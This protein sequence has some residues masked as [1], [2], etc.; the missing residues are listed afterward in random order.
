[1][2]LGIII[3]QFINLINQNKNQMKKL[4]VLMC[5]IA[6]LSLVFTSCKKDPDQPI[7]DI[8]EDGFYVLGAA[9]GY[10]DLTVK[11]VSACQMANGKNEVSKAAREGMYEKYI[12]LEGGKDFMILEK[13]GDKNNQYT[14]ALE[15]KNI[16]TDGVDLEGG[17]WGKV[18][19]GTAMMQVKETGLYH[20]VLDMNL[21]KQ[22]DAA[23]GAQIIIAPVVWG[24]RGAMNGWSYTKFDGEAKENGAIT[25]AWKNQEMGADNAEFKFAHGN[26]WKINL[27]VAEQVKA[28][29]SL[30]KDMAAGGEN[31]VVAE[32]GMY[33]ITLTFQMSKGEIAKSFSMEAKK[34]GDIAVKDYSAV[35]LE[36]VGDAVADQ[37]GATPDASSWGWGNVYPLGKPVKSGDIYTWKSAG[38]VKLLGGKKYKVRTKGFADQGD[39]KAFDNGADIE[40]AA[41]TEVEI[42]VVLDAQSGKMTV[43]DGSVPADPVMVTVKA[44]MPADWTET[45]TAWVWPTGGDGV[46]AELTK[47]G[48]WYVYTTPE[49][50]TALNIIWRNGNDWGKGQ[51]VNVEGLR[52]NACYTI[53]DATDVDAEGKRNVTSVDCQ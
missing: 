44:K 33:D 26:F 46:A 38:K 11:G 39:I 3:T 49:P 52:A 9:A 34:V 18:S 27:D 7:T 48:D 14:A 42:T 22:L 51:T 25:W 23:G 41:D 15:Q 5:A 8:V 30:G 36:L 29:V 50:V 20:I 10:A 24:V 31:I 21:D 13:A 2:P 17:Y 1:M 12:V 45:P 28:E 32:K 43:D 53:G 40:V 47:E 6:A 19:A 35:E 4:S 16:T 37:A